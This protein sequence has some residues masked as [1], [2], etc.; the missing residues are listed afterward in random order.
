MRRTTRT[1]ILFA[2][3]SGVAWGEDQE[4]TAEQVAFF[5]SKIRP[6]LADACYECHSNEGGRVKGGLALDTRHAMMLG[7]DSGSVVEP[8][9]P[10]NSLLWIAMSYTDGDYEMPPKKPLD[11]AII[12]DF[13]TWIAMGAPDPR[14]TEAVVVQSEIDIEEGKKFWAFQHPQRVSVSIEGDSSWTSSEIDRYVLEKLLESSLQPAPDADPETLVRRLSYDLTGL[15]PSPDQQ[16]KFLA[17]WQ[18]NPRIATEAL[19]DG[20]LASEQFGERWGRHWLD[21][22][23]YAESTGKETNMTFPHAW[24]YRDFVI[25]SFN[26]DKP[27]DQFLRQ[28]IAG[29]LLPAKTDEQWQENLIATGY[30]ALGSKGLNQDN[31][32]QFQMDVVDEQIDT[33]TQSVLGLTVACARCHDHKFDPIP[34]SDYYALA[35]IFLSTE[36]H[37]GT[38]TNAQNKRPSDL[39]LLPVADPVGE[40]VSGEEVAGLKDR[41]EGMRRDMA[42]YRQNRDNMTGNA[43]GAAAQKALRNRA[44]MSLLEARLS[45][46]EDDGNQKTFAMGV[47]PADK[48]VDAA[49]LVRGEIDKPAQTVSRGFVQVLDHAETPVIKPGANGRRELA[50]WLISKENALTSRVMVN[51]IWL[52][53]FGEGI[54]RTPDNF[55]VTGEAPTHPE[56]LD[57]L[58]LR[59]MEKDWSVKSMIREMVLSR[60]YRMGSDFSSDFYAQ[61]PEN[62]L[63]WRANPRRLDAEAIRDSILSA[64]GEIDL[65]RPRASSIAEVG[66]V[67]VGIRVNEDSLNAPS[68]Y[69][70]VYLPVVRDVVPEALGLF[71][72]AEPDVV[73]GSRE[74][75][76]V[77]SQA[78]YLMNNSF[79]S[80][81]A[82]A[83]ATR[84][85]GGFEKIED[86]IEEGFRLTYGRS[87]DAGELESTKTLFRKMA[88]QSSGS[89]RGDEA[90]LLALS[91]FCQGLLS[92]AEFR[93]LY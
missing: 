88:S 40:P 13:R 21:V 43:A 84:L 63:L 89:A 6:V 19:V 57:Y 81:Q 17:A 66:D 69:R 56:L 30:L 76:N 27:Y 4:L 14:V 72:F 92:S 20:L 26:S 67:R 75:T 42:E 58:A 39:L 60:T 24:R 35:G 52:H 49:V 91:M 33:M 70:S 47:Q 51:R 50:D 83:M 64:S 68:P 80:D 61:D 82:E 73:R 71:D 90:Q 31:G 85:L 3:M 5:E 12:E 46:L 93:Y 38:V 78:L 48:P 37:F 79:V 86:R 53:L 1:I 10:E 54:V 22:A 77:P 41:L 34:T 65:T 15:P 9:D 25:D 8:G 11:P 32:R 23:R 7:G 55:G 16:R 62:K 87:P 45:G 28:Q 59:F 29:D 36:T 18:E 2:I 44:Q 74:S